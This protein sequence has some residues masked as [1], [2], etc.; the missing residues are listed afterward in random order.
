[1]A[2]SLLRGQMDYLLFFSG[3]SLIVLAAVC[4]Q[5]KRAAW[6]APRRRRSAAVV[7]EPTT[8]T[9]AAAM[10]VASRGS[11]RMAPSPQTS[12]N[13]AALEQITGAPQA[14]ASRGQ[15]PKPS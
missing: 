12:G 11:T 3:L 14:I 6:A 5:L 1:M 4:A 7:A 8:R 10:A 9:M 15:K 13:D 2:A